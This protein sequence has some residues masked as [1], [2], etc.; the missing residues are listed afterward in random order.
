[1]AHKGQ[2]L[3]WAWSCG[4]EEGHGKD[5]ERC[6]A[7]AKQGFETEELARKAAEKHAKNTWHLYYDRYI[8]TYKD[9]FPR[10]R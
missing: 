2:K 6:M 8:N 9:W 4:Y 3:M 5:W 10:R 1:M 7:E